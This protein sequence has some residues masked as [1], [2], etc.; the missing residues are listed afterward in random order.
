MAWKPGR[1]GVGSGSGGEREE[2][3]SLGMCSGS[4]RLVPG[5]CRASEA[6]RESGLRNSDEEDEDV[7]GICG[8]RSRCCLRPRTGSG[9]RIVRAW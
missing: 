4:S 3:T 7:L 8:I 5:I 6:T 2:D 1:G 9:E